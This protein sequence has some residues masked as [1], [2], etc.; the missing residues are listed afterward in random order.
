MMDLPVMLRAATSEAFQTGVVASWNC[1]KS[2]SM[3]VSAVRTPT[4]ALVTLLAR[5]QLTRGVL[6]LMSMAAEYISAI[7]LPCGHVDQDLIHTNLSEI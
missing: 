3:S 7:S 4:T 6:G 1:E 2:E 5:L